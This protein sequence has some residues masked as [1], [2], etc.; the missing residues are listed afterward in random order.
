MSESHI[1]CHTP[2]A[3]QNRLKLYTCLI[4]SW[5]AFFRNCRPLSGLVVPHGRPTML[6]EAAVCQLATVENRNYLHTCPGL[7]NEGQESQTKCVGVPPHTS[8]LLSS[9]DTTSLSSPDRFESYLGLS[10]F[11]I[12]SH[13]VFLLT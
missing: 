12:R 5:F 4:I 7:A 10:V 2:S 3:N 6:T 9:H 1:F 13:G 8:P 11:A